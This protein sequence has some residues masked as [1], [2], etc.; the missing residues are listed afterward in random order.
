[1]ELL[2]DKKVIQFNDNFVINGIQKNDDLD[3]ISWKIELSKELLSFWDI[4][5][6]DTGEKKDI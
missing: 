6:E 1:M 2:K 4:I 5:I 3:F